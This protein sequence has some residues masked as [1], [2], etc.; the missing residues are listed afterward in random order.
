VSTTPISADVTAACQSVVWCCHP[1]RSANSANS[2]ALRPT[3]VCIVG[4][5]STSKNLATFN[6]AFEWARPMNFEPNIAML[7]VVVISRR[8]LVE[9]VCGEMEAHRLWSF[10]RR[11]EIDS[12]PFVGRPQRRRHQLEH[13]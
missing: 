8:S 4:R 13:V 9:G 7:M 1:Q 6:H 11:R 2:A 12:A 5:G 3:T 10:A